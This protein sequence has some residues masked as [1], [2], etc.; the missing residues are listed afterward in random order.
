MKSYSEQ[1]YPAAY[2]VRLTW[3]DMTTDYDGIK[4]L[5]EGHALWRAHDNWPDAIAVEIVGLELTQ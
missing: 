5:N 2:M 3:A 4:G 1:R